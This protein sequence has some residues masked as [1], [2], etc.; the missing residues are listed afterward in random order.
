M[1]FLVPQQLESKRLRLRQFADSDWQDLHQYFSD[2]EATLFTHGRAL[3]AGETWRVMCSMIGHWQI[4]GYGPYAVEEK[5][6]GSVLGTV[7]FWYPND[8]PDPEIKWGLAR[9]HWGQGFATEAAR[10]VHAAGRE[11]LP[12]IAFISLI[13]DDNK[14][15]IGVALAIG[16][17][18]ER[19][20]DYEGE[21]HGVFRHRTS[22]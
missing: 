20:I 17:R 15:S 8:W 10:L 19:A 2:P 5:T 3:S 14:A 12:D 18:R 21:P 1:E 13:H 16:A 7:G 9:R 22:D 11:H 4:R 6:S